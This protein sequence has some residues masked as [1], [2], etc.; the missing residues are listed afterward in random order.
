[1]VQS[2]KNIKKNNPDELNEQIRKKAYEIFK[3]KPE[4]KGNELSDWLQAEKEIIKSRDSKE[5]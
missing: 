1:M 3:K 2:K 4:G 5:K